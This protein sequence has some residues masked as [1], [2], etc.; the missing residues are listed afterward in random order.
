MQNISY[1]HVM[2]EEPEYLI[3]LGNLSDS[4]KAELQSL[5]PIKEFSK[6]TLL[7]REG[8][9]ARDAYFVLSGCIRSYYLREGEDI[10]TAF[11]TENESCASLNS[12]NNQV[13][14][15]HFLECIEACKVIVLNYEKEK[16]IIQKYPAMESMCRIS[17]ESDFG[18]S[19]EALAYYLTQNPEE[20]YLTLLN[21]RP[22]LFQRIPQYQLASYLGVK[23]ESLS[24]L[25]KRLAEKAKKNPN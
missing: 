12:F 9:V 3:A 4:E 20:R 21:Q 14:A 8:E 25:K 23:P 17:V 13:P 2:N 11:Y 19:Q 1:F 16:E 10:T 15:N 6:G 22:E 7:L 18:K 24:R 5:M